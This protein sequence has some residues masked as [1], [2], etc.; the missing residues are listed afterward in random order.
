MQQIAL[1]TQDSSLIQAEFEQAWRE[2]V[3]PLLQAQLASP[4]Q[5]LNL[6]LT[7]YYGAATANFLEVRRCAVLLEG[8][9]S[10]QDAAS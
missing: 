1:D 2:A 6:Y 4:Q 3:H 10:V 8:V 9:E 5:S 7:L